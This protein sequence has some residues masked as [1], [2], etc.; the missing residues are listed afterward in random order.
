MADHCYQRN[1]A[2]AEGKMPVRVIDPVARSPRQW[3]WSIIAVVYNI[4]SASAHTVRV[5]TIELNIVYNI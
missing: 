5:Y 1:Q 4:H 2:K 3:L